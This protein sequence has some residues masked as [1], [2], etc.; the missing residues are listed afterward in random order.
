MS[1]DLAYF[2]VNTEY[3]LKTTGGSKQG[4]NLQDI[5]FD[6][7][8]R[9][10]N[11][12]SLDLDATYQH[13]NRSS[14]NFNK[15]STADFDINFKFADERTLGFGQ[16]YL[17]KGSNEITAQ[18]NWRLNPKWKF[19]LYQ[20][21]DIGNHPTNSKG[22]LEQE[23]SITRDLHCWDVSLTYNTKW[24]AGESLF[25]IFRIKAFPENDFGFN[26]TYN[27]PKKGSIENPN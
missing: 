5:L 6:L 23:Y 19:S 2:K 8:L 24:G 3:K 10:Y 27:A 4:G 9:P 21:R 26:Q 16:R 12:L 22:L 25:L 14:E 17:R 7:E 1:I 15:F 11:W 20:R 18:L 13:T